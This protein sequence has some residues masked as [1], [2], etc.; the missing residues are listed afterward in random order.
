[1]ISPRF[2][3]AE[4]YYAEEWKRQIIN[5]GGDENVA[6]QAVALAALNGLFDPIRALPVPA[7]VE[8]GETAPLE[9]MYGEY[10]PV[11]VRATSGPSD[12]PALEQAEP[13][14]YVRPH[15]KNQIGK[16][17]LTTV[18]AEKHGRDGD[19][20]VYAHPQPVDAESIK[21]AMIAN[22]IARLLAGG[23]K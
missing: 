10:T 18:Y 20:P 19:V 4:S 2:N 13:V 9:S 14:G 6:Q 7:T 3:A 5:A 16:V 12:T 11:T 21:S 23:A 15:F 22:A 8:S 17:G 1:M